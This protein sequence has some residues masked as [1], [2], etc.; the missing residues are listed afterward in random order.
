MDKSPTHHLNILQHFIFDNTEFNVT[1]LWNNDK[2]LFR[3]SDVAKVLSVKNIHTSLCNFDEDEKVFRI[4]NTPGGPQKVCFLTETGLYR[5]LFKSRKPIA[6]MFQKWIANVVKDIE[7][8]A[9]FEVE[10]LKAELES[11]KSKDHMSIIISKHETLLSL[12]H[13]RRV[14]YFGKIREIGGKNLIKIGGTKNIRKTFLERHPKDYG[15]IYAI[16]AIESEQYIEFEQFLLHHHY[17]QQFMYRKPVKLDGKVSIETVLV[18]DEELE[19]II[20]IAKVNS[21]KY[22]AAIVKN[23]RL[24]ELEEQINRQVIQLKEIKELIINSFGEKNTSEETYDKVSDEATKTD[25][26]SGEITPESDSEEELDSEALLKQMPPLKKKKRIR[27]TNQFKG[28]GKC[29]DC[30]TDV[31]ISTKRC[32]NCHKPDRIFEVSKETLYDL[33]WNQKMPFTKI[34]KKFGVSD[35]AIRKRCRA[36]GIEVRKVKKFKTI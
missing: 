6:K 25:Q 17:I 18:T 14:V 33:V 20:R 4:V 23:E 2:P 8:N 34:G 26:L 9:K 31:G 12:H 1:I 27:K 29:I 35:N 10:N 24:D 19:K 13:K 30:G 28:N 36:L 16:Y 15:E 3:A 7:Q 22:P 21:R 11:V 5:L 32:N